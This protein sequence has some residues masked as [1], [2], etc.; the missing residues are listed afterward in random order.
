VEFAYLKVM[1]CLP[2]DAEKLKEICTSIFPVGS[3]HSDKENCQAGITCPTWLLQVLKI[4]EAEGFLVRQNGIQGS[5]QTVKRI[6]E[7]QE[8]KSGAGTFVISFVREI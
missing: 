5:K 3:K 2:P 1:G 4:L 7:E 8:S 6:F